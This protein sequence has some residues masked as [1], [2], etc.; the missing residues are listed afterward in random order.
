MPVFLAMTAYDN[1]P[2]ASGRSG[3]PVVM[4]TVLLLFPRALF[5]NFW[6]H[7]AGLSNQSIALAIAALDASA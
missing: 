7:H 4:A 2:N 6:D 3:W 5:S 1:R